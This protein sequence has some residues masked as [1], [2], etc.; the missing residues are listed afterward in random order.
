MKTCQYVGCGKVAEFTITLKVGKK[1]S[2]DCCHK[3]APRWVKLGKEN[4]FY[5]VAKINQEAA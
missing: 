2:L 4:Q 3:C 1:Q 5:T